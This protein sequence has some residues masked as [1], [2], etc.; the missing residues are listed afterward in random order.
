MSEEEK[1]KEQFIGGLG[2]LHQQVTETEGTEAPQDMAEEQIETGFGYGSYQY[3]ARYIRQ[4]IR[5]LP[6]S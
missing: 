3:R 4:R 5:S 2:N 1:T 6:W